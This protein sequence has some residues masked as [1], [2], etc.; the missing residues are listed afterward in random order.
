M[1]IKDF[2]SSTLVQIC[3]GIEDAQKNLNDCSAVISPRVWM[4]DK[5]LQ[6]AEKREKVHSRILAS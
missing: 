4:N 5:K 2:V 3:N 1:D 6:T